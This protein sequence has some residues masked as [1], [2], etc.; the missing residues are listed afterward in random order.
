MLFRKHEW[1]FLRNLAVADVRR[2]NQS[3]IAIL[4]ADPLFSL[5]C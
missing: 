4:G 3:E 2:N 5:S 1:N